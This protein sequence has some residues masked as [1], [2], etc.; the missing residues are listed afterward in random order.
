M[1]QPSRETSPSG[2]QIAEEAVLVLKGTPL[3]VLAVYYIGALPFVAGAITFWGAMLQSAGATTILPLA[4]LGMAVLFVWMKTWQARFCHVLMAGLKNEPPAPLTAGRWLRSASFQAIIQMTG[5]FTLPFAV[6]TAFP[7]GWV[8]A[9]YQNATVLDDG[10]GASAREV[11]DHATAQAKLW[12]AQNHIVIWLLSPFLVLLMAGL[13][14]AFLPVMDSLS[15]LLLG[16]LAYLYAVLLS[17][18]FVPLAPVGIIVALNLGAGLMFGA[19]ML[20]SFLGVETILSQSGNAVQNSTFIAIICGMTYLVLDPTI[21]TAYVLRCFY[22]RSRRNGEDLRILLRRVRRMSAW[23]MIFAG[24]AAMMMV[25]LPVSA[26]EDA[27]APVARPNA[28]TAQQLDKAL[29]QELSRMRYTWRMPRPAPDPNQE[30]F[31][32]RTLRNI[33]ETIRG[34]AKKTVDAI[35]RFF[36]W[37]L[38]RDRV[39]SKDRTPRTLDSIKDILRVV[40]VVL[41]IILI[42]AIGVLLFRLWKQRRQETPV[43]AVLGSTPVPDVADE[44]T[45]ADQLPEEGWLGMAQTLMEQ[46]ECRL[47]IR[48]LF[49][50]ML[51]RM[52]RL[53]LI[54]IAR[55]KSNRDYGVELARHQHARPE[56]LPAFRQGAGIYESVWYGEHEANKDGFDAVYACHERVGG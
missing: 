7:F 49:L 18:A 50:A 2:L 43:L 11:F 19:Q 13:Y 23:M 37:L 33:S 36:D 5:F 22:G 47:A 41:V 56:L 35:D 27:A 29:N 42:G 39:F 17:I 8:Y 46:G 16:G 21:K 38:D 45:S 30:G 40:L 55:F 54:R 3:A 48:A 53:D 12:P 52:S 32:V 10:G 9:T 15:P 51:A 31:I 28:V 25:A 6:M 34:A 26:Q 44:N 4:A 14:L 24:T 20:D 1:M